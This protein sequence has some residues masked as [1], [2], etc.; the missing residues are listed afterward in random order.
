MSKHF[1]L[2]H[3][4]HERHIMN[5]LFDLS[6]TR[7]S[8]PL[9]FRFFIQPLIAILLAFR[10]GRRDAMQGEPPILF[11]FMTSP[12]NRKKELR[13]VINSILIPVI[14]GTVLDGVFQI[15]VYGSIRPLQA[16]FV[17]FLL[18]GF[19]YFL[20]RGTTNRIVTKF[21]Q[22]EKGNKNAQ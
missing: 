9:H 8:G 19:P 6:G 11:D 17:G 15:M 16:F 3:Y 1:Y 14:I 21:S 5:D 13:S 22:K 12:T 18:I 7:F 10:D 4:D 2:I 20:V